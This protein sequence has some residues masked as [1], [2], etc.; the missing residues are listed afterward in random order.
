MKLI[1]QTIRSL[2]AG[3]EQRTL[4]K[5]ATLTDKIKSV[6]KSANRDVANIRT[7]MVDKMDS[8]DPIGTGAFSM[9]RMPNTYV[10]RHSHAECFKATASAENSHA[11]GQQTTASGISAHSEGQI[12]T[13]SGIGSHAEGRST[14]ASGIGSHAEGEST[15]ASGAGSHA[16]GEST[17]ASGDNSHAEGIKTTAVA[18][19]CHAE[20]TETVAGRSRY[21]HGACHAEG[22]ATSALG[23]ASHAEGRGTL[24]EGDYSHVEGYYTIADHSYSHV[25]GKYNI[26]DAYGAYAHIVGNGTAESTDKRSN[27]H[28]LDWSGNAT[29]A[30][31]VT[32]TGADY[33]EYFEWADGNPDD[34][35]R[36]GSIVTLDGEKI[37][38]ANAGDEI[39]GVVSGTAMVLGDNAEWEWRQKYLVDDYGRV[40]T[41]MV[42]EFHEETTPETNEVTKTSLGFFPHRKLNPD[43][44]PEKT[45][46]RRCDRKEW[47]TI[48][49][50]GKIHVTDDGTCV[51]GGYATVA[52]GGIATASDAKTN[53]LVMKR[54][55]D[56]IVLVL[57][58]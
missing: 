31:V 58:K 26:R 25:Q 16:E 7:A 6:E 41:E 22:R 55:T 33:A 30:G 53:M 23:G 21:A 45:Y 13:A 52:D 19:D 2:I 27:A 34:E 51:V 49:L 14:T 4:T 57:L 39:L 36:V 54:I 10:A 43:F 48:G 56:N 20:G 40:I 29:F 11:E 46:E 15:T 1:L 8:A 17:T 9:N 18:S 42:E 38:L 24:A 35:D 28:T 37:R 44:D 3:L 12:T 50:L 5:I 47:E 32:G